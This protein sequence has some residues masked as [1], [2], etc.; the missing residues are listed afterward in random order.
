MLISLQCIHRDL[1]ARNILLSRDCVCKLADFGLARDVI[2]GGVYQRKSQGRVP[3]RWM[4]L[5]SLIDNVYTI[6]SDVW[7][8][9]VLLWE[10]ITIGSYPYPGMSS[11]R[12]ISDLQKGFRMPKP[13]H[14]NDDV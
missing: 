10:I 8:F 1:A 11:K 4:A 12:L 14:A 6:Q 2:N 9:G 3:I 13:D 5:E 7:S